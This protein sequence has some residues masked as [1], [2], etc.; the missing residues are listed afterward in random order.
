MARSFSSWERLFSGHMLLAEDFIKGFLVDSFHQNGRVRRTT[1]IHRHLVQSHV[2]FNRKLSRH[3]VS[4]LLI[5]RDLTFRLSPESA[6]G[7]FHAV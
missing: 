6:I 2:S 1:W 7:Q 4:D 5:F 3:W